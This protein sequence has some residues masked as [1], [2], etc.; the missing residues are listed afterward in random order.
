MGKVVDLRPPTLEADVG[1]WLGALLRSRY[2]YSPAFVADFT[3]RASGLTK[4][5]C[6]DGVYPVRFA[7]WREA[8]ALPPELLEAAR[9]LLARLIRE[10]QMLGV[11][12]A[13]AVAAFEQVSAEWR[14]PRRDP[15]D[16]PGAA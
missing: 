1:E 15:P 6:E 2:N 16:G 12:R 14:S 13:V 8:R 4:R 5:I 3:A 7:H 9:P 11:A 10:T